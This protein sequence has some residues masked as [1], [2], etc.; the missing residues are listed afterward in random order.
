MW[1]EE[2]TTLFRTKSLTIRMGR[3]LKGWSGARAGRVATNSDTRR[4]TAEGGKDLREQNMF[5]NT[6]TNFQVS[7]AQLSSLQSPINE[8]VPH[9]GTSERVSDPTVPCCPE[10]WNH[11][12]R[13]NLQEDDAINIFCK[14]SFSQ[15]IKELAGILIINPHESWSKM[16]KYQ[17]ANRMV[18]G[19]S[20]S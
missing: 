13:R 19:G 8:Y 3:E 10:R 15:T 12:G 2:K 1:D 11:R 17:R 18:P 14:I 16:H 4:V 5:N 9:V 7:F 20:W 6:R